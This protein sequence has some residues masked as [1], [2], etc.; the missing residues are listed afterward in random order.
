[1]TELMIQTFSG[2]VV[3]S[4]DVEG[5][6]LLFFQFL[7]KDPQGK[8]HHIGCTAGGRMMEETYI[9]VVKLSIRSCSVEESRHG[10]HQQLRLFMV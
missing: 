2:A 8:A 9:S 10:S 3:P 6:A 1:M 4:S 5:V 7:W